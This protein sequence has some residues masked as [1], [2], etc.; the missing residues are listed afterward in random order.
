MKT[1][2]VAQTL[3]LAPGWLIIFHFGPKFCFSPFQ[4]KRFFAAVGLSM[5]ARGT[6]DD[7]SAV[8]APTVTC[9]ICLNDRRAHCCKILNDQNREQT[10]GRILNNKICQKMLIYIQAFTALSLSRA[11]FYCKMGKSIQ[12]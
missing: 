12:L 10:L 11:L 9:S 1:R 6:T 7:F 3:I 2:E 4:E 8:V 5:S